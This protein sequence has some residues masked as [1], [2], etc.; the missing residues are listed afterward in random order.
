MIQDKIEDKNINKKN[1]IEAGD[2]I[3]VDY[4]MEKIVKGIDWV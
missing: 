2:I 4:D 3:L 1:T